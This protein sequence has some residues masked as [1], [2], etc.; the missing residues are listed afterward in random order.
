M[1]TLNLH[2]SWIKP[3]FVC[4]MMLVCVGFVFAD[5]DYYEEWH[6][7]TGAEYDAHGVEW[8]THNITIP[9]DGGREYKTFDKTSLVWVSSVSINGSGT[10]GAFISGRSVTLG[11]Y[12]IGKYPV[13]QELFQ[14]VMSDNPSIGTSS[15]VAKG[16]KQNLR[17]VD[18]VDFYDIA[19][20]CNLLSKMHGLEQAYTINGTTITCDVTKSGWRLPTEAEWEC[21]ARGGKPSD[22]AAWNNVYAG[23]KNEKDLLNYAWLKDNSNGVTHEVG[24]KKPNALGLYDMLGNVYE[25]CL[26]VNGTITKGSVKNPTGAASGMTRVQR[27]SAKGSASNITVQTRDSGSQEKYWS[28]VGFRLCRSYVDKYAYY[29]APQITFGDYDNIKL[30]GK[31]YNKTSFVGMRASSVNGLGTKGVFITGRTVNLDAFIIGRYPVTQDLYEAVVKKIPNAKYPTPSKGKSDSLTK[32][33][34]Q[35]LRPVE[36]IDFIE[37]ATFCNKLSE[38]QGLQPVF[39]IK[40]DTVTADITKNGW[41]VPTEAEWEFVARGGNPDERSVWNSY[42]A[43]ASGTADLTKY[44][45]IKDNSNNVTHE[46]G[47]KE[48]NTLGIYDMLGN[49]YEW[50]LDINEDITT[51][52]FT[53]P[54]GAKA[55]TARAQRGSSKGSDS[56]INVRTRDSGEQSKYWNDVGFRLCRTSNMAAE[57]KDFSMTVTAV[58]GRNVP[59]SNNW[60]DDERGD[61]YGSVAAQGLLS[62]LSGNTLTIYLPVTITEPDYSVTMKTTAEGKIKAPSIKNEINGNGDIGDYANFTVWGWDDN[63]YPRASFVWNFKES[64]KFEYIFADGTSK[65]FTVKVKPCSVMTI[66]WNGEYTIRFWYKDID[67]NYELKVSD[68]IFEKNDCGAKVEKLV[69]MGSDPKNGAHYA[70]Y[71]SAKNEG[72]LIYGIKKGDGSLVAK[73]APYADDVLGLRYIDDYWIKNSSSFSDIVIDGKTF[74]KTGFVEMTGTYVYGEG[75]TG[76]FVEGRNVYLSTFMIGQ[77]PVTQD[78]YEAVVKKIP[79]AK[80]PTPSKGKSDTLTKGETQGLRPVECVDFIEVATFCNKLSE[81]QGLEP[82]FTIK[83][84]TVTA[85]ITK[86]GWRVPTEAEW[87]YAARGA[88]STDGKKDLFAGA[89]DANDVVNYAWVKSNSNGVSHEVGLKKPNVFGLYDMLGNVYEWCLDLYGPVQDDEWAENPTGATSGTE[90]VQRGSAKGSASSITTTTRDKGEQTKYWSDVGFRLCRNGSQ[91]K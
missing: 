17:P 24:L 80:Y 57:M 19:V 61:G 11:D 44:A 51:G 69:K 31:T 64:E 75:D 32:G 21:A 28:D 59:R 52:S 23:A 88:T 74:Q 58:N 35:G 37:V 16:E 45:W 34:T 42:Y 38:L 87:E 78:L 39:T 14:A 70:L 41:R 68:I 15:N 54:T 82:V 79:N 5:Y 65:A 47:L 29:E 13:T 22:T 89:K 7:T 8:N 1:K 66:D 67:P 43:G 91:Y 40:G 46:V 9:I 18:Q 76:V 25:W 86:N 20:F 2:S 53:N 62:S 63:P 30:D 85:D 36:F 6:P 72:E 4:L 26:D 33:E 50:C 81:L 71:I 49:V 3:L 10:N 56:S 83:G 77:Y 84:D 73:A 55:G 48:P 60:M 90:R 27:G 12:A